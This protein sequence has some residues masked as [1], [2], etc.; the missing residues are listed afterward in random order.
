MRAMDAPWTILHGGALGDLVLALHLALRLTAGRRP[1]LTVLSRTDPGD[2]SACTPPI[3]RRSSETVGVH[4]L[5]G[6]PKTPP[7][8]LSELVRGR[9]VLSF[10]GGPTD[11][12]HERLRLLRP[13]AL[14]A[15]DPRPE[16]G[17]TRHIVAQWMAQLEAQGLLAPK[18]VHQWPDEVGLGVP[19]TWREGR[20]GGAG[21]AELAGGAASRSAVLLHPGSGG[22]AKCWPLAAFR[23][24]ARRLRA[25]ELGSKTEPVFVLGPVE[26]ERWPAA[27]IAALRGEF[28]VVEPKPADLPRRLAA[29]AAYVGNDAGPTHL[30]ALLGTPTVALF[31]PTAAAVWRPRGPRVAVLAGDETDVAWG[32]TSDA[33]LEA[34]R[35]LLTATG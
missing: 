1:T 34:L 8:P 25:G 22:Q 35:T 33:V 30:A 18:S 31:G 23:A 21:W 15:V 11:A 13:A 32:L 14:W 24:L 29:A 26:L 12:V 28:R 2:L 10:L 7:A 27:E 19:E 20:S 4:W 5:F 6:G 16:P 17:A 9:N 3:H